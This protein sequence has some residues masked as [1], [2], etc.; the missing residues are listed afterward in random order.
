MLALEREHA[1]DAFVDAPEKFAGVVVIAM[2]SD[3][4]EVFTAEDA[5]THTHYELFIEL[6]PR[7]DERL[8]RAL[9]A[10]WQCAALYGPFADK[11]HEP[12][13]Q[14]RAD[15]AALLA[16]EGPRFP[17]RSYGIATLPG[18]EHV[19][20]GTWAWRVRPGK[21]GA[22]DEEGTD[23]LDFYVPLG[24]L[25]RVWPEAMPYP[26]LASDEEAAQHAEWQ[27]RLE[28]FLAEVGRH[29]FAVVGFRFAIIGHELEILDED[30]ARWQRWETALPTDRWQGVLVP[31]N[32]ELTWHPPTRRG[33]WVLEKAP[34]NPSSWAEIFAPSDED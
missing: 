3:M 6:G 28:T 22:R 9:N 18:G 30:F 13:D 17:G 27:E 15:P 29:L 10:V 32:N 4:D 14:A 34:D 25:F 19:A 20:C 31:R 2:M 5:W 7:D 24:S 26:F 1:E 16:E 12:R 21:P 23:W 11:E 8:V 33:G